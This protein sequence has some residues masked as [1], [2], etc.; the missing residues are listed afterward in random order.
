MENSDLR[1]NNAWRNLFKLVKQWREDEAT[2]F[3]QLSE[4]EHLRTVKHW[5]MAATSSSRLTSPA[6]S[7]V[8]FANGEL[9]L[10]IVR[11]EW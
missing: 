6:I 10:R 8:S 3:V 7:I 11:E 4:A 1:L 5:R 9:E 2:L